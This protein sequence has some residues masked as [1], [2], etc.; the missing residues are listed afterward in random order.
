[1]EIARNVLRHKLRSSLTILGILIGALALTTMGALAEN[2]NAL[3]DGGVKFFGSSIQVGPPDGASATILPIT[4]L[5]EIKRVDGV[6]A[7]FPGYAFAAKPG[8]VTTVSFGV[9]DEIIAGD[10]AENNWS[11]IKLTTSS[12]HYLTGTDGEVVLGSQ[13]DKEFNKK[14]GDTIDLPIK[15]ADAK[16]DFVNH[17]FRV[18]G[19]LNVTRTAPDSFAYVNVADGQMLLKDSLPA[20]LQGAIDVTQI[21]EGI[22]VYGKPGASLG[23][24]DKL[25]DKINAEITGVKATRP[26]VVVNSFRSGGAIFTA[27]TTAAALLA[28]IIGGLSV[29][30]TMFMAVAERVREIGLKKAVGATTMNVMR[31]FLLEA[32]FIGLVG[33]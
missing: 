7:A 25:A 18:V 17:S 31:E 5:D 2:F 28:L 22:D 10:P 13:I 19:I 16:P 15:P 8:S 14:V 20:S 11:G 21:T 3:L 1:M 24:L 30:N 23:D 4:K 27:I 29:V 32:T 9:P 12:G 33:G 6:Q 26:S